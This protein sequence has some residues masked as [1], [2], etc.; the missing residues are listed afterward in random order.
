MQDLSTLQ[1]QTETTSVN[2]RTTQTVFDA[3]T[4]TY[5]TT[6]PAGRISTSR[7]DAQGRVTHTQVGTLTPV[8]FTY[9]AQ[10]RLTTIAQGPRQSA[11]A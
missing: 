10:G 11:I 2:G 3:A 8:D 9:D 5:T 1:T 7:I 6:T 4:R